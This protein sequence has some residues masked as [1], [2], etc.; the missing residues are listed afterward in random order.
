M[1]LLNLHNFFNL[2]QIIHSFWKLLEKNLSY[3]HLKTEK[4]VV[5][6]VR[7]ENS[8]ITHIEVNKE[9]YRTPYKFKPMSASPVIAFWSTNHWYNQAELQPVSTAQAPH[10]FLGATQIEQ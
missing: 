10:S 1:D 7:M 6:S 9:A 3:G 8:R 5:Y 2:H 4:K